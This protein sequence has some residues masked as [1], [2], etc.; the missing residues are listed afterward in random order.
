ME[1]RR[2]QVSVEYLIVVTFVTFL[3]IGVVGVALY[4]STSLKESI[5]FYQLG[6]FAE[7]VISSAESVFYSGSPSKATITAYLPGG[8]TGIE[9]MEN[10]I[11]FT[12]STNNGEAI[13]AYSS[14]VPITWVGGQPI[15]SSKGLKRIEI[16]AVSDAVEISE[17]G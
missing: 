17:V 11:V 10:Q 14:N 3:V 15:S 1:K 13:T 8:I 4:Y 16:K 5:K 12:I 6:G 7:K 2:G 9:I